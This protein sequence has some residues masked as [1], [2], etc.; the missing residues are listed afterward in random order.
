MNCKLSRVTAARTVRLISNANHKPPVLERLAS[1]FGARSHLEAL[2]SVT[3]GRQE[4]QQ[5]GIPGV[6]P[7]AMAKGYGYQY[8]NAAFAYA[9]PNGSRFNP[10]EWGAW[11]CALEPETSLQEV[12]Y[13]LTRAIEACGAD[14]DNETRYIELRADL[15]AE[16]VDV[17]GLDPRPDYL[18]EDTGTAYPAGQKFASDARTNGLNG[19]VYPSVRHV[20]GTCV[21]VFWPALIQNF[22][23][24]ETWVLKWEGQPVPTIAK[25]SDVRR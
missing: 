1:S 21:A 5:K 6:A 19:I 9:R 12:A 25:I 24:G 23:Q 3:S 4:A 2:E 13:H 11:Y 20:G 16:F 17:R 18:H 8:V 7:E 15:D 10:A 14:Y 22:Q